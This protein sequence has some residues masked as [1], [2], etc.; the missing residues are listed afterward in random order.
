[1]QRLYQWQAEDHFAEAE[2]QYLSKDDA[3]T[4]A[5]TDVSKL[6]TRP[7]WPLTTV[8]TRHC[9]VLCMAPIHMGGPSS[10][11]LSRRC[12]TLT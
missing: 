3:V 5:Q 10:M 12:D 1:M 6:P 9:I 2:D 8:R 7:T 11:M 4:D